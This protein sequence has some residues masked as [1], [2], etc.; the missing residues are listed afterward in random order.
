MAIPGMKPTFEVRGKLRCGIK[1]ERNLPQSVDYFVS[2]DTAF[3]EH[4]GQQPR[5]VEICFP[6]A[7]AADNFRTG[8]EQ[9]EGKL[10][11]CYN[12][13]EKGEDVALRKATMKK[14]GTQEVD[15]LAGFT[16]LDPTPIGQDRRKVTCLARECPMMQQTPRKCKPT[17]RLAFFVV[18]LPASEGTFEFITHSWNSL[19]K[20]D[21]FLSLLHGDVRGRKFYLCVKM[22]QRG[23]D[24]F[25]IV[26]LEED[27]Q[28][29][30]KH[31]VAV[32]DMLLQLDKAVS[33]GDDVAIKSAFA[34]YLDVA[35]PGWRDNVGLIDKIK[36]MGSTDAAKSALAKAL[37]NEG[38]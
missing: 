1:N 26:W 25:P 27:V 22:E 21:G 35:Q 20:I 10:L 9:W 31:D 19:E 18:G 38:V 37:P 8:L 34:L 4:V 13:G 28:I 32:A 12:D 23:R 2:G 29:D 33:G 16:V 3:A 36:E 15:L 5:R 11:A 6:H 30:N 14:G 7:V 17:G 24:K